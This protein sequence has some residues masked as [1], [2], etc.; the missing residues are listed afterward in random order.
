MKK[1]AVVV[2]LFLGLFMYS[3]GN[4]GDKKD[5]KVDQKENK[6]QQADE[7]VKVKP[8]KATKKA[9]T[10]IDGKQVFRFGTDAPKK[11]AK[12]VTKRDVTLDVAI[13]DFEK[14]VK[15]ATTCEEL[16]AACRTFDYDIK[17]LSKKDSNVKVTQIENRQDVMDI[18]KQSEEKSLS[19]CQTSV[20][21]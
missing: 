9:D 12:E 14:G 10:V 21:R 20:M 2:S 11:T 8:R 6:V 13:K 7:K 3:C 4:Q 15:E 16:M 17:N 19:L 1:I 5:V 18:R